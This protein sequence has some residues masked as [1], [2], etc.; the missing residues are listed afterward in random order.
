MHLF[1]TTFD[2]FLLLYDVAFILENLI[3]NI[4]YFIP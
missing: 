1:R 4:K 2:D 3:K